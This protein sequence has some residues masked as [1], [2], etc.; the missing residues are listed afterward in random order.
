MTSP[1]GPP[2]GNDPQSWGQQ[3]TYGGGQYPAP[4]AGG[5]PAQ[6]GG[7]GQQGG[8]PQPQPGYGQ[9]PVYGQPQPGYPQQPQPQY[10]GY[11]QKPGE[12]Y[13]G[14]Y[15]QQPQPQYPGY[16]QPGGGFGP[17]F[18][19]F[20]QQPAPKSTG[21]IWTIVVV[22]VVLVAAAAILGFVWPGWFNTKV[23]D[24]ASVQDGVKN[25]VQNTYKS[26]NV[27]SVSCPPGQQVKAGN[28]FDCTITVDGQQKTVHVT[29]KDASGQYEVG[30]PK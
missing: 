10:P 11:G 25:I 26:G 12:Q 2:G 7:Y 5:V 14:G 19:G 28:S 8:Y 29:V 15:G 13:P 17:D 23:L 21:L 27:S 22:V 18:G 1:Y 24:Q 30:Q 9:P 6:P 4:Q 3:P 20:E 16:Q